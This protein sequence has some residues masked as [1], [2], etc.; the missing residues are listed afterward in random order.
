MWF[1]FQTV[2]QLSNFGFRGVRHFCEEGFVKI[3]ISLENF[4]QIFCYLSILGINILEFSVNT[5][6]VLRE[7]PNFHA[8]VIQIFHNGGKQHFGWLC[9][10]SRSY[11]IICM[12][13][14]AD[15]DQEIAQSDSH[16]IVFMSVGNLFISKSI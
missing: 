13:V 9:R 1:S 11:D 7:L 10:Y 2:D 3:F 5:K 16:Q 4:D 14:W 6:I 12:E 8:L 15:S